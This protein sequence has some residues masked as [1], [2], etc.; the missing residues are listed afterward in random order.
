[1]TDPD[2]SLAGRTALITGAARRLGRAMAV[3]LAGQG[4]HV[5]VHHNRSEPEAIALCEEIHRS[6]G[7]AWR[8]QGDLADADQAARVFEDAVA[9]A[10]AIDILINNASVFEPDT[11]WDATED[12]VLA[13]LRIHALAPLTLARRMARQGGQGHI[14]NLLDTR[15]AVYDKEHVSYHISKRIL[16]MLTRMLAMELAPKIAVNGIAPG[17]ILPPAGQDESYLEKLAYTNPLKCHGSP[18]DITDAVLFLLRSRFIT[19]QILYI[20]G[21]Y[22]MKGR[23]YD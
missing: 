18:Q 6:G 8:V 17:L 1:M 16:A 4:I 20:D 14:I 2:T 10:G 15:V 9:Q 3:T 19:G 22:H 13:N 11:I 21:G 7:S 23:M 5:V 12:S